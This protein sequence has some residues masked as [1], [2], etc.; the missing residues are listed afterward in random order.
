M[1]P[2]NYDYFG[3]QPEFAKMVALAKERA[4]DTRPIQ[5]TPAAEISRLMVKIQARSNEGRLTENDLVEEFR[6]MDALVEKSKEK[7]GDDAAQILFLKAMLYVQLF[8]NPEKCKDLIRQIKRDFP[9]TEPARQ[10][11]KIITVVDQGAEKIKIR[12]TLTV[13]KP[14]PGFE[15]KDLAG[16]PLSP[17][18][19]KGKV[20]LI[21]F[22]ATWC[23][24]CMA[25]LP[26]VRKIYENYHTQGFEI[27]GI[28]LDEE[29]SKVTSFVERQ[30]LAWPQYCDGA[31]WGNKLAAQYGVD[32]IPATY[33]L[34]REGNIIAKDLRGDALEEAVAKA[35]TK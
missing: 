20:L 34:D 18:N 26:N 3:G 12:D 15:E 14:F 8:N 29:Q 1:D 17:A 4:A 25:E 21:D 16:K 9:G 10:A 22:W 31:G 13:G 35:L 19:Y 7:S 11:D 24:P 5:L 28:S 6:Q 27:I 33:L 32:S 23:M 30:K 2:V